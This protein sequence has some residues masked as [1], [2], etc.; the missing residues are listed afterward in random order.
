MLSSVRGQ[1]WRSSRRWQSRLGLGLVSQPASLRGYSSR[2]K[3]KL[4]MDMAV[5]FGIVL[6]WLGPFALIFS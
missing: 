5:P 3:E 4:A 6:R 1:R 2:K